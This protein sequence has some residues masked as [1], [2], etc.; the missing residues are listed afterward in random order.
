MI[1]DGQFEGPFCRWHEDGTLAE[2][3][4]LQKGQPDGTAESFYPSGFM[5]ARA[6]LRGGHVLLQ[7]QWADG[8]RRAAADHITRTAEP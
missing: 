7:E 6:T 3:L 4:M 5:K 1:V 8:E 2:R